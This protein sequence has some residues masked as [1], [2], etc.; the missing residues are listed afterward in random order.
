M[1]VP[2]RLALV[3]DIHHGAPNKTKKGEA[4]IPLLR[5]FVVHANAMAPDLVIDLGDRISDVD[6]ATD[7][8]LEAEVSDVF[9]DLEPPRIHMLGNH[10][11]AYLDA[12]ANAD[13]LGTDMA[14]TVVDLKAVRLIQWQANVRYDRIAGMAVT[15][16][17]LDWLSTVLA[18]DDRPTVVVTHV[19]LDNASMTGN[20]YFQ[21]NPHLAGYRNGNDIRRVLQASGTVIACLA[22]HTHWNKLSTIDGIQFITVQSLTESFTTGGEASAAWAEVAIDDSIRWRTTGNDPIDMVLPR[23]SHNRRWVA[24]QPSLADLRRNAGLDLGRVNGFILD[25]DGVV[26]RGSELLNGAA[27][28]LREQ[29]T[30]GRGIVALTNNAQADANAYAD[31]LSSLGVAFPAP[32]IITAGEATASWLAQHNLLSAYVLGSPALHRALADVGVIETDA[33]DVVVVGMTPDATMAELL[34]A[35][36][37]LSRGARLVA[38][39]PDTQLPVEGGQVTAECGALVAFLESASGRKAEVIGKPNQWMFQLALE[40]MGLR[41]QEV[42]MVGDTPATDIAGA[43]N[44]GL[45]SALVAT[46]NVD[47]TTIVPTV[48]V[49]D[50]AALNELV[51]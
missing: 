6:A 47:D 31:K 41:A 29:R 48:R 11:M 42:L 46:G 22:G 23:R 43:I 8:Q 44:A 7:R 19:P 39:N 12:T 50:L 14:H 1:T 5:E 21:N 17:D 24:P 45:R 10:D 9:A 49:A 34:A 25:L 38:T 33:P 35:V 51:R 30:A 28:F 18:S 15:D 26:Y 20:F 27:D 4:A 13:V 36:G 40:H 3:T 32:A 2:L 16:A 37:Y